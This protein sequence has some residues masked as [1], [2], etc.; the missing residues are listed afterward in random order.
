M[1]AFNEGRLHKKQDKVKIDRVV[2]PFDA[3]EINGLFDLTSDS[4]AEG[5]KIIESPTP[6]EMDDALKLIAK[7]RSKW[8]TSPKGM[9][10]LAPACLIPEAHLWLYFIKRSLLSTRHDTLMWHFCVFTASVRVKL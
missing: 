5:N 8:N 6:V 1:R 9:K 4:E 3:W 2:V 10:T 7:P